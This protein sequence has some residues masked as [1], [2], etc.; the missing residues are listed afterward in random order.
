MDANK[1]YHAEPDGFGGMIFPE[2][3]VEKLLSFSTITFEDPNFRQ[4]D[5]MMLFEAVAG[6]V[7][8]VT[9]KGYKAQLSH[10]GEETITIDDGTKAKVGDR[11]IHWTDDFGP[12]GRTYT[13]TFNNGAAEGKTAAALAEYNDGDSVIMSLVGR[14]IDFVPTIEKHVAY[15][16]RVVLDGVAYPSVIL[17]NEGRD[18]RHILVKTEKGWTIGGTLA[19]DQHRRNVAIRQFEEMDHEGLI[20]Q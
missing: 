7:I 19:Q 5:D 11:V 15:P 18:E 20:T 6:T 1:T 2:E 17:A 16:R 9:P 13:V 12:A 3:S 8:E 4:T 10:D 14:N